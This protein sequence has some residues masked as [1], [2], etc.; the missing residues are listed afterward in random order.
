[1]SFSDV[2]NVRMRSLTPGARVKLRFGKS[3]VKSN[4]DTFV[5]AVLDRHDTEGDKHLMVFRETDA[6]GNVT[7]LVI[8][9]YPGA[10][11]KYG[12]LY[13][14]LSAVD[15]RTFTIRKVASPPETDVIGH[16]VKLIRDEYEDVY[17]WEQL[18]ALLLEIQTG[19]RVNT[20]VKTLAI[21]LAHALVSELS[22][23]DKEDSEDEAGEE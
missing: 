11:W 20:A 23:L 5:E 21:Q 1:M 16:A 8:S 18:T 3:A 10:K 14:S 7:D 15:E 9:H 13:A 17:A 4:D 6:D 2:R 19:K 22:E 12:S